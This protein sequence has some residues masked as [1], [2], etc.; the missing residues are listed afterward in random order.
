MTRCCTI[1]ATWKVQIISQAERSLK[2]EELLNTRDG[3]GG[4]VYI[5]SPRAFKRPGN[6]L[7]LLAY[8]DHS[9]C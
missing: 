7:V 3:G 2:R 6:S 8:C 4:L 9:L 1:D 5:C